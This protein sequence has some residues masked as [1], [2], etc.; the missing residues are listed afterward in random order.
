M[1]WLRRLV[2]GILQPR[3]EIDSRSF[4]MGI[5]MDKVTLGQAFSRVLRVSPLCVV[6]TMLHTYLHLKFL[7]PEGQSGE[8]WE[9]SRFVAL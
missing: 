9:P 6:L 1:S 5:L 2:I 7:V 4:H 3:H 8:A